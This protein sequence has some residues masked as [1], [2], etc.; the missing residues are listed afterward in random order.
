MIVEYVRLKY[1]SATAFFNVKLGGIPQQFATSSLIQQY[2]NIYK[3]WNRYA[4]AIVIL[5]TRLILIE[6]KIPAKV[7]AVSQLLFYRDLLL[8][9]PEFVGYAALPVQLVLVT[10][11]PDPA[12]VVFANKSGI[13]VELYQPPWIIDYLNN[14]L[15]GTVPIVGP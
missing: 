15:K 13:T 5:A 7:A 12:L 6:A 3:S 11:Q 9:T 10:A 2:P 1:P 8:T 14:L 4:D